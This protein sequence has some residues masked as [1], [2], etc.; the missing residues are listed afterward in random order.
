[1]SDTL[2]YLNIWM[3][4]YPRFENK[5]PTPMLAVTTPS[6]RLREIELSE[7][8]LLRMLNAIGVALNRMRLM[9]EDAAKASK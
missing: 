9:R 5:P 6:G 3:H 8:Q 2:Q 1:M 7:D 4:E